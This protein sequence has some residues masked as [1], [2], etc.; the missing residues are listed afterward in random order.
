MGARF[1]LRGQKTGKPIEVIGFIPVLVVA[2][3]LI[4]IEVRVY[5]T[6]F[7][8]KTLWDWLQLLIIPVVLALGGYLF[9]YTMG[10]TEREIAFDRQCEVAL[11]AYLDKISELLLE[12]QL[13]QSAPEDEVR[14]IARVRTLTVLPRLD[15][16][17]KKSVLQFLHESGLIDNINAIVDMKGANLKN[18]DLNFFHLTRASLVGADLSAATLFNA[19]LDGTNLSEAGLIEANLRLAY[20]TNTIL[21]GAYLGGA[22]LSH[23]NLT[24]ADLTAANLR[25]VNL[26]KADL[27][28][29]NLSDTYL[30]E[31]NLSETAV[32]A[33]QLAKAKSLKGATM[34]DGTIHE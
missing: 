14:K 19:H 12:K 17:R 10:R 9:T 3:A 33:K 2:I 1:Y 26:S 13:R 16:R 32:T 22:D 11:Q 6:G 24:G 29:V 27:I 28:G 30:S 23:S 18:A 7:T 4:F 34:P 15:S 25:N 21:C 5:G 31:A 20:L 8:G